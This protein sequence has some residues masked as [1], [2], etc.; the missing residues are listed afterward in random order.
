MALRHEQ[1]WIP[2]TLLMVMSA[3]LAACDGQAP[4]VPLAA[5]T[6]VAMGSPVSLAPALT[7]TPTPSPTVTPTSTPTATPTITPTPTPHPLTIIHMR[8]QTY[9]GSDLTIEQTLAPGFNYSR[10]IASYLSEGLK[11]YALLTVPR[12]VKPANGW[13]VVVFNHGYIPPSEY[14]TTERYIAYT[15]AFSRNGYI[16]LK[17]DYRG[18]G[19]SE[20]RPSSAYSSPAY[21][22][23]VL[24]AVAS[25]K[26][27]KDADSNR[28]GMWGHSM[29]G[30]ITLRAM[31]VSKDIK[32][33]VIW[34]GVVAPFSR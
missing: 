25:I 14:R 33:G 20:G 17:S 4:A 8:G 10:Y 28:I 16:V 5:A 9:P 24:N 26:R 13:P 12:G 6:P 7:P 30:Q 29:G 31:V 21:T 18:H 32:A 23:D 19:D 15:D 34:G 2:L 1:N 27:F 22:V 3:L 11:L